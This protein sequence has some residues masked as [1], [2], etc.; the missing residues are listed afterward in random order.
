MQL[1]SPNHEAEIFWIIK[2]SCTKTMKQAKTRNIDRKVFKR[3]GEIKM[4][5]P[6]LAPAGCSN[7]SSRQNPFAKSLNS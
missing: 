4:H 5:P 1:H 7:Y 6:I 2:T 3:M